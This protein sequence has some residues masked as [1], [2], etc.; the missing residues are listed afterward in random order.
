LSG[1]TGLRLSRFR[2]GLY[3]EA[4]GL[5]ALAEYLSER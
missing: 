2:E 5:Q 4:L 1:S 3:G